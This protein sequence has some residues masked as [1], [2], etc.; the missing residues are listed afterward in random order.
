TI[1]S[2]LFQCKLGSF[3]ACTNLCKGGFSGRGKII[4]KGRKTAIVGC[5]ELDQRYEVTRFQHA[6][7]HLFGSFDFWIDRVD[8]PDKHTS[9]RAQI[10]AHNLQNAL[11]VGF[12]CELH[13]EAPESRLKRE[14]NN[15][16]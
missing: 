9:W 5:S 8:N 3:D 4:A 1:L 7:S 10:V 11:S 13:V 6:V 14:G 2:K 16:E 15:P 12:A